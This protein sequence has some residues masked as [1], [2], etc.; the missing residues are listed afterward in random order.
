M[1][2]ILCWVGICVISS[3]GWV[4]VW[5][6][7]LGGYICGFLYAPI[8]A[9]LFERVAHYDTPPP[10]TGPSPPIRGLRMRLHT[11][12]APSPSTSNKSSESVPTPAALRPAP[13]P[14]A[15]AAEAKRL[16][17]EAL[18]L[19]EEEED[20]ELKLRR[21]V[22]ESCSSHGRLGLGLFEGG[23]GIVRGVP[24]YTGWPHF[25]GLE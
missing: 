10:P 15:R 14:S 2:G 23:F 17:E 3:I 24:L 21:K 16:R 6:P 9:G 22:R 1:C 8:P 5:Y 20:R 12:V 25:R 4:F 19:Q 18:R 11:S 7:L 13:R